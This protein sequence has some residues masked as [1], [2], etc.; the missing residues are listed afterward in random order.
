[1]GRSLVTL[2]YILHKV[3]TNT[4]P[5][6]GPGCIMQKKIR[7]YNSER[8]PHFEDCGPLTSV[9]KIFQAQKPWKD[10][11]GQE[12]ARRVGEAIDFFGMDPHEMSLPQAMKYLFVF[13][14]QALH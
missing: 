9:H 8:G 13:Y 1:M 6:A 5:A 2:Q 12:K 14:R 7:Q 3:L 11:L 10:R 4:L